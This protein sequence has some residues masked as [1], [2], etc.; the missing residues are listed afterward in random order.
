M[1]FDNR[2]EKEITVFSIFK[3]VKHDFPLI[4]KVYLCPWDKILGRSQEKDFKPKAQ[5]SNIDQVI[6]VLYPSVNSLLDQC[7]E[8]REKDE[9]LRKVVPYALAG[10]QE[11][12]SMLFFAQKIVAMVNRYQ[13]T[14]VLNIGG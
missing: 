9:H 12:L 4:A 5:S 2:K 8:T 13:S 7:P 6:C 10:R 1:S 11:T 14:P 3:C